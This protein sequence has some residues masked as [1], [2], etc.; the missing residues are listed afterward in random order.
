MGYRTIEIGL[1]FYD[2]INKQTRN[3]TYFNTFITE[4]IC[5]NN[6][7]PPFQIGDSEGSPAISAFNL[8]NEQTGATT[9]LLA[10]FNANTVE[11]E[12]FDYEKYYIY[13][14]TVDI[15]LSSGRY[16]LYATNGDRE[17]FSEVFVVKNIT[18]GGDK[19]LINS[20]DYLL[21]NATDNLLI[22]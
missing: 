7:L 15:S 6:R 22:S 1:P 16:Y 17:W 14:G 9:D 20:V 8:V 21:I 10:H 4:W 3:K 11:V 19:L 18:V 5:E 2:D 13:Y 12:A